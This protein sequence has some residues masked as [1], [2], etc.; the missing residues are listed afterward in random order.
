M[1]FFVLFAQ[2]GAVQLF[3]LFYFL[4]L[5]YPRYLPILTLDGTSATLSEKEVFDMKHIHMRRMVTD[6]TWRIEKQ[7]AV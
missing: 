7:E 4:L 5:I 3:G 2:I 1:G 6:D